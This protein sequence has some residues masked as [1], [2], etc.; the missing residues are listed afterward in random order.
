MIASQ[1]AAS[2]GGLVDDDRRRPRASRRASSRPVRRC[3][4]IA[5]SSTR[6]VRRSPP[7][8]SHASSRAE[9]TP[10]VRHALRPHRRRRCC[11]RR[12]PTAIPTRRRSSSG[13]IAREPARTA[14]HAVPRRSPTPA[15]T[16]SS[17]R[18]HVA[19][20]RRARRQRARRRDRQREDLDRRRP[21][22]PTAR[23]ARDG[24]RAA[25][26]GASAHRPTKR[27]RCSRRL[28]ERHG[29]GGSGEPHR[30]EPYFSSFLVADADGG[31]V[32]ETSNR[33]W[34][35]RPVD[36]GAAISNRISLDARTGRARSADV[37]RGHRLRRLP[38]AAHAD[39]DRRR[40][41]RARRAP[42]SRSGGATTPAISPA[43]L[44]EP[45]STIGAADGAAGRDRVPTGRLHGVHAP[46]RVALA[47][48]RVDD[49]RAAHRRRRRARG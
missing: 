23:A 24:S 39:R 42:P 15:R 20:G 46:A 22:R 14:A 35:A 10:D 26:P 32:V 48:D 2:L 18:A 1:L 40:P 16:R 34:A 5:S 29:Q 9:A 4:G 11:S 19:V 17:V 33:T 3:V 37:A 8:C 6:R 30:D 41:A 21:A 7:R 25:R 49:R 47:D 27:S 12:T 36:A 45:R 13:T 44:R 43:T 28:L 31:F 38:V